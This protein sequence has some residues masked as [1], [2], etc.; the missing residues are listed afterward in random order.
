MSIFCG[1]LI[2][3]F[4]FCIILSY[5]QVQA[6][7]QQS[8]DLLNQS[9]ARF[10]TIKKFA[11]L[12]EP[13]TEARGELTA[14]LKVKRKAVEAHYREILDAFYDGSLAKE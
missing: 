6:L 10:E 2:P 3:F 9:L 14:S 12:P 8:I 5:A 13:F 11:I 1:F 4:G 7:I